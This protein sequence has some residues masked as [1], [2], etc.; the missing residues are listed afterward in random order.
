MLVL[1]FYVKINITMQIDKNKILERANRVCKETLMGT[2]NME[3][4]D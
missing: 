3:F 4:V 2:L 1:Y